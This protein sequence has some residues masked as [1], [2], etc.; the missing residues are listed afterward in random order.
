MLSA[1][2]LLF[3]AAGSVSPP[4]PA[5]PLGYSTWQWAT[6]SH[7]GT[8]QGQYTSVN[9]STCRAQADAM[10]EKGLVAAGYTVFVVDEPC[11]AGRDSSGALVANKTTWPS[12]FAAFGKYLSDRGMQLGI[13]TDAGPY[14]C[15]GCPASAGHEEQDVETFV[16]WGAAYV[17]VDRCFGVDSNTMRENLPQTFAK[18]RAAADRVPHRVQI[19]AILAATDN[20][21]EW[22][23]GTCDHCRT[24]GDIR[25]SFGSMEGHVDEQQSIPFIAD[26]AGPGYFNDLDMMIL[27]KM[28]SKY[29]G[30]PGLT[31]AEE[32]AH[33]A[34][35][36]VLKSPILLS[37]D[38]RSLTP[39]TLALLTNDEMLAI[40][41]DPLAQQARRLHTP[42]GSA[43]PSALTFET[44][45]RKG[46]IPLERQQ[47]TLEKGKIVS[48]ASSRVVTLSNCGFDGSGR[49][50]SRLIMCGA[51]AKS[52]QP[53]GPGCKNTTCPAASSFNVSS[54]KVLSQHI[55]NAIDGRCVEGMLG[56]QRSSVV[57]N[58]CKAENIKQVWTF[59]SDG[60]LRASNNQ[61]SQCLTAEARKTGTD[62]PGRQD[63][64]TV[65]I[66][67]GSLSN[68]DAVVVFFNRGSDAASATLE[69][70]ELQGWAVGDV[71]V[72][73]DVWGKA[74]RTKAD[75][76]LSSGQ[77]ESHGVAFL[78]L[79]KRKSGQSDQ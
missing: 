64:G 71:A 51:D 36:A 41:N 3:G 74:N 59:G 67:A 25:N 79:S 34:L 42:T 52:P 49:P 72:V 18:Y 78:R 53:P 21:W 50:H 1:L 66:F 58:L 17:K 6:G 61:T 2:L 15:Q 22:C 45:P 43:T 46:Q 70:S 28:D 29:Y 12:G 38:V 19:S 48:K 33:V 37:C 40:F 30:G 9:E 32:K 20:C 60:T 69:L 10:V 63:Q 23:N 56:P 39:Q 47:W 31:P 76:Q 77:I 16:S 73:R 13:Y 8:K 62:R 11:F 26:Y 24:T 7:W 14:T 57:T 75:G 65:D 35:W 68:G 4:L 44:C 27:G 5:P 55:T 54:G